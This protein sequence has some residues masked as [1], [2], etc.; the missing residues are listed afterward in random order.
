MRRAST[1]GRGGV[2]IT[3]R[4]DTLK[5]SRVN[6][7]AG[8]HQRGPPARRAEKLYD[9][10]A[11]HG[12]YGPRIRWRTRPRVRRSAKSAASEREAMLAV[13]GRAPMPAINATAH[14]C[15]VVGELFSDSYEPSGTGSRWSLSCRRV[16]YRSAVWL[17]SAAADGCCSEVELIELAHRQK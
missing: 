8:T 14:R 4:Q 16:C 10:P 7:T 2:R 11:D 17:E 5:A 6:A 9:V 13:T 3:V 15:P 12:L 1:Y